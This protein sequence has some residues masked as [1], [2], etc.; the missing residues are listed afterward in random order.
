[1]GTTPPRTLIADDQPDVL[2]ALRLLLKGEGYETEAV[3]SP[4]DVLEAIKARNFDLLLMDLNYA[5]DTTSGQEGLDLLTRVQAMDSTLP[6]VVMTAW[7]S[8][9]VAVEA[10][11]RG[12][13]DF[14]LKPWENNR[15]LDTLRTQIESGY[16]IREKL[17][18][19]A[20]QRQELEDAMEIQRRL[21]PKELPQIEGF[22]VSAAWRPAR[23][24]SG[25][26]F[27]AL[28]FDASRLALCIADV[29]GKGMAAA[30][31]MSNIQAVVKAV[32]S[33]TVSPAELCAR[34]NRVVSANTAD[35]KFITFFYCML[36]AKRM[37]LTYSNAGH[38]PGVVARRDGSMLRLERGGTVLGPFARC[39]F[40]QG[41]IPV[42]SGDRI[43]LFTDGVTEA[44]NEK[45]DE[46]GEERLI[47]LLARNLSL[48]SDAL[49]QLLMQAVFD[50]SGGDF[51]DDAT[52]IVCSVD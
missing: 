34:V 28:K 2:E 7:G 40:E 51:Q 49:Q 47:D 31:L 5:R 14:V 8:V 15:L 24:V 25:D 12:V 4:G 32:A 19:S 37:R 23:S 16:A 6:V 11:H 18:L 26:Y 3:T 22:K 27:D 52:L 39:V 33:E 13:R 35:D 17:R 42:E 46:F 36:D 50:F 48:D 29:S 1:M 43:L 30:L 9:E 45:G 20:E 41:E 21:L 10:M 38:N 44:R